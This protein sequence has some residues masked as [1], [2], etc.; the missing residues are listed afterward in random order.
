MSDENPAPLAEGAPPRAV[1]YSEMSALMLRYAKLKEGTRESYERFAVEA[2]TTAEREA[3]MRFAAQALDEAEVFAGAWRIFHLLQ[4]TE[5][6][7]K[8]VREAAASERAGVIEPD[9]YR[10]D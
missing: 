10:Y 6:L 3:C 8:K 7:R 4:S 2:P 1:R 5:W 9:L